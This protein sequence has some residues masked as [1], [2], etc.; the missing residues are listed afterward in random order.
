[1]QPRPGGQRGSIS[2]YELLDNI[3]QGGMGVVYRARDTKLDRIVALKFLRVSTLE[4]ETGRHR[5]IHEAQAISRL[6]HRHIAVIHAIEECEGEVF[7]VF[8][9][10]PGGTLRSRLDEQHSR[11]EKM[12]PRMAA[13]YA[14]QIAEGLSHA[15]AHGIIHRDI[16]PSNLMF[17][18]N[19]DLKIVDFGVSRLRG[20]TQITHTGAMIGTPMYMS[21]EQAQG[22]EIDER[23]D[24]F[25][26]GVVLYEMAAGR[27]PFEIGRA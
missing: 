12:P 17:A 25:S 14:Y 9:Y 5:F 19:G 4:S 7:L 6:T 24:I 22:K 3:G 11:S 8:E 10:L 15:H 2:H 16:K 13:T 21:P 27:P 23:T 20:R 18:G 26:L 1:M